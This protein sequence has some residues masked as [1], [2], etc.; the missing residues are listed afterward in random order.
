MTTGAQS[1]QG[2]KK[3]ALALGI[4]MIAMM[5]ATV[6]LVHDYGASRPTEERPGRSH[7][8]IIHSK[9]VYLTNGE[10]TL[11]FAMHGITIVVIG[12][13]VGT[14]LKATFAKS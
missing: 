14:G 10:Y 7:A 2:L 13:F 12:L 8:A 1:K 5:I 3:L 11:A 6:Y 9:T 4:A